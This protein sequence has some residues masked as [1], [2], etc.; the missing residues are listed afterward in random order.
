MDLN[1]TLRDIA[2]GVSMLVT[3]GVS[4][5]RLSSVLGKIN[6]QLALIEKRLDDVT[7]KLYDFEKRIRELEK[8]LWKRGE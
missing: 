1:I 5:W 8:H 6:T 7:P 3:M 4:V 2:Y